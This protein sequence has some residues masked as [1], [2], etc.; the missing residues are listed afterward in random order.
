MNSFFFLSHSEESLHGDEQQD[1]RHELK[2]SNNMQSHL[3][4]DLNEFREDPDSSFFTY[5]M[6]LMFVI[7]TFYVAYH[8][9]S[10]ILAL[11]IEGRRSRTYSSRNGC[12][13]KSHSAEY[14]RLDSNLEEAIQ[15]GGGQ[16]LTT[17][18]IY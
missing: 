16:V 5:F 4:A 6:F 2:N 11:L 12:R 18:I 10:K 14:R 17:Q 3:S 13:R 7:V 8:N 1:I 9:K 15:S